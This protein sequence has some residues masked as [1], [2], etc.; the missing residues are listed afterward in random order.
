M[1]WVREK[2][3]KKTIIRLF[4]F[5]IVVSG[6]HYSYNFFIPKY[7]KHQKVSGISL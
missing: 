2:I 7:L 6:I 3:S 4:M 1:N 5:I